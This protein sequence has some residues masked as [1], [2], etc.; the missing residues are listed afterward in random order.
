MNFLPAALVVSLFPVVFLSVLAGQESAE[1][2]TE[3][4]LRNLS[5]NQLEERLEKID[6]DLQNLAN[7]SLRSGIGSIGYRSSPHQTSE[8]EEW[9]EI[10]FE[11]IHTIDEVVLVPTIWRDTEKGF[12]SD[13]FPRG[14]EIWA[15][16]D[17]QREGTL[18]CKIVPEDNVHPGIAPMVIPVHG[19]LASW[20]RIKATHLSERAFDHQYV[21]QLSEVLVFSGTENVALRKPLLT[22][23]NGDDASGAW[24]N[25]FIVDGFMPYLMDSAHGPQSIAYVS[26]I[27]RFPSFVI[28]LGRSYLLSRIHMHS[29]DQSD[30]VPQAYAGDLGIPRSL[31]VEGANQN[32]FS[33]AT[34]LLEYQRESIN[35]TG[36]VIARSLKQASCRYIRLIPFAREDVTQG[37]HRIGFAE[38]ELFSDGQNVALGREVSLDPAPIEGVYS[39]PTTSL[40]D[41]NNLYGTILPIRQWMQELA[42]RHELEVERPLVITELNNRYARQKARLYLMTRLA[43]LLLVCIGFTILIDRNIRMKQAARIKERFAADLHDELGANLHSLGLLSDLAKESVDDKEELLELLDRTRAFTERSGMAA[44]YCT[45]MLEAKGLCEDLVDEMERTTRRLLADLKYKLS[46]EGEDILHNLRPRKRIDLFFFYKEAL[47]NII[48]HSG[49]TWVDTRIIA[50]E[51]QIRLS[52]TDNGHGIPD[53]GSP[54]KAIPPSLKRRARLLR[55]KVFLEHPA[56]GGTRIILKLKNSRFPFFK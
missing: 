4:I 22:S 14:F 27:G 34:V 38:I 21:F 53:S 47:T 11:Q 49:A 26:Q 33:D 7:Y 12:Q 15:G 1:S 43:L 51:K 54:D 32:D 29:V 48:K 56:A 5:L 35:D 44:R 18:I 40:T 3:S 39:R 16:T 10:D 9:I 52:I 31:I 23:T 17:E 42:S 55:G 36:P 46:F 6:A 2:A 24:D 8:N 20:I 30:T 45:N 19:H 13:A 41:G 28:D 25:R 37:M 50:D